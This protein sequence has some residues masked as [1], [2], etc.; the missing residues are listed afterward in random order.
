MAHK[1]GVSQSVSRSK[2]GAGRKRRKQ[3]PVLAEETAFC[4]YCFKPFLRTVNSG[5]KFCSPTSERKKNWERK[6][7]LVGAVCTQFK[8][9][10]WRASGDLL[11]VAKRCVEAAYDALLICMIRLGWK[12]SEVDKVWRLPPKVRPA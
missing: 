6:Q 4:A 5:R 3:R 10:G 12:Y 7:A 1:R 8:R 9:W 2:A 11:I